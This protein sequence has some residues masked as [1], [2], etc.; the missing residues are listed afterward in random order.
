MSAWQYFWATWRRASTDSWHGNKLSPGWGK[1]S[2]QGNLINAPGVIRKCTR[3]PEGHFFATS[4][5]KDFARLGFPSQDPE[6]IIRAS[7][8]F[9]SL[10]TS[11]EKGS[12]WA[13]EMHDLNVSTSSLFSGSSVHHSIPREYNRTVGWKP[14]ISGKKSLMVSY[15][16][17]C[18]SRN[19]GSLS[20]AWI[21]SQCFI[22][23]SRENPTLRS[24]G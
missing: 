1:S 5:S 15:Q 6:M 7:S 8:G 11:I 19:G 4:S 21:S 2:G 3:F 22:H 24:D 14:L 10:R 17:R 23:D 16:A 13:S 18:S 9:E 20:C 12:F